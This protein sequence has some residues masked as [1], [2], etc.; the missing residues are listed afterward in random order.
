MS[1]AGLSGGCLCGAVRYRVEGVPAR[2]GLC[3]CSLCRRNSG[4]VF[5]TLAVYNQDQLAVEQGEQGSFDTP[6]YRRHFCRACGSATY[7]TCLSDDTLDLHIGTLDDPAAL[8]PTYE[9]WTE[10]AAG[11]VPRD[12]TWLSYP[13][14]RTGPA[15][16]DEE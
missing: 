11:W 2:V 7:S 1:G 3:H 5:A 9:L 13:R 8:L 4:A 15:A 14:E 12:G 6:N 16:R 10:D